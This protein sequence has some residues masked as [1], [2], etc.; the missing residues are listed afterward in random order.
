M[1]NHIRQI[2]SWSRHSGRFHVRLAQ[3]HFTIPSPFGKRTCMVFQLLREPF[4]MTGRRL[5]CRG[6]PLKV[7]K[8]FLNLVLQGLDFLHSECKVIHW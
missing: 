3:D 8:P 1:S 4:W 2:S 6:V 7:L 5:G